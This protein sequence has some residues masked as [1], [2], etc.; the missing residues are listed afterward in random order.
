MNTNVAQKIPHPP[1]FPQPNPCVCKQWACLIGFKNLSWDCWNLLAI[2]TS[3]AHICIFAFVVIYLCLITKTWRTISLVQ[4]FVSLLLF[5]DD[6]FFWTGIF[7][8]LHFVFWLHP[9]SMTQDVFSTLLSFKGIFLNLRPSYGCEK[10]VVITW[11]RCTPPQG[12][13]FFF[14]ERWE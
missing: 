13:V 8:V 14:W 9:D 5:Y 12:R 4:V 3:M 10:K 11:D 2:E 1:P 7:Q 6:I